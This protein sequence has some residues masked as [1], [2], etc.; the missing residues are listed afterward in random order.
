ML[1]RALRLRA[2][3]DFASLVCV[4]RPRLQDGWTTLYVAAWCGQLE[5][6][7]VLVEAGADVNAKNEMVRSRRGAYSELARCTCADKARR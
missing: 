6:V 1:P 3:A 7:R 5:C 4:L 2:A